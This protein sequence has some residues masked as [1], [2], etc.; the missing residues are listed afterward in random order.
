M[1]IQ[2]FPSVWSSFSLYLYMVAMFSSFSCQ[3]EPICSDILAKEAK[4]HWLSLICPI[5]LFY[6]MIAF[7][8]I[9]NYCIIQLIPSPPSPEGFVDLFL[10]RF[11]ASEEWQILCR[12]SRSFC[13]TSLSWNHSKPSILINIWW[14]GDRPEADRIQVFVYWSVGSCK[15]SGRLFLCLLG[16]SYIHF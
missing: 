13:A 2:F 7:I 9:W 5:I 14:Q 12:H 8:T 3:L 10:I 11:L 16:H 15:S 4:P 1:L 6:F